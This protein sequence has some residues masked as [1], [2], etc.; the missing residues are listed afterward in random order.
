MVSQGGEPSCGVALVMATAQVALDITDTVVLPAADV[1]FH[2]ASRT[3]VSDGAGACDTVIICVSPPAVTVIVPT[4]G[5]APVLG[6]AC[7]FTINDPLP[8]RSAGAILLIVNQATSLD[9]VHCLLDVTFTV[10]RPA[11]CDRSHLLTER[12]NTAGGGAWVT[13][14]VRDT[15]PA[16]A[17]VAT[18]NVPIL[19][20][21]PVL[22]VVLI[23][24]WLL[25]VRLPSGT[26]S[27]VSQPALLVIV[28]HMV[29]ELTFITV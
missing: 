4:L 16:P 20:A 9:T 12:D 24:N 6:L 25:P 13:V 10:V 21:I 28:G 7:A 29:F 18:V 5:R 11:I 26:F 8:V 22:A 2:N 17:G 14:T 1:G 27:K 3:I 19:S 15:E 23:I